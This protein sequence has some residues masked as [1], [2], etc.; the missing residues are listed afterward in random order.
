MTAKDKDVMLALIG[1][2]AAAS[3]LGSGSE[4]DVT[5]WITRSMWNAWCRAVDIPENSE[6]SEWRIHDCRKDATGEMTEEALKTGVSEGLHD[7]GF[8]L[9][10][11][12]R[13]PFIS[14]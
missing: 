7:V 12:F 2:V 6:P 10:V 8:R 5:T 9:G 3:L 1:Q 13:Y 14:Q 11:H 4:R